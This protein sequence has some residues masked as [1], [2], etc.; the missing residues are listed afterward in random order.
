VSSWVRY[1]FEHLKK[2]REYAVKIA[3]A[4]RDVVPDAQVYVIGGVAENRVT[5]YSD[6]DILVSL[7]TRTLDDNLVKKLKVEILA[8][9]MDNY[10]LPWIAPVEIHIAD[11]KTI[12]RYMKTCKKLIPIEEQGNTDSS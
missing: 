8:R 4:T 2:W 11:A 1:H 12:E 6:I 7:P 10:N 3:K 5:I 9:A